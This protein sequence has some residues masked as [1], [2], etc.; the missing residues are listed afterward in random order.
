MPCRL[1]GTSVC[2][3]DAAGLL[4]GAGTTEGATAATAGSVVCVTGAAGCTAARLAAK[5]SSSASLTEESATSAKTAPTGRVS[6]TRAIIL[7]SVPAKGASRTLTI[8]LVSISQISCPLAKRSPSWMAHRASTPSS[9]ERPH[10]GISSVLI[11][12]IA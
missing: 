6:P 3:M 11:S 4:A 12:L 7:R 10:F 9:I 8:L 2:P 5:A 1:V